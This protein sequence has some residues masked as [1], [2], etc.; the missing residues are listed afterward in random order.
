MPLG[1]IRFEGDEV[2]FRDGT[3]GGVGEDE[4]EWLWTGVI[5]ADLA[6]LQVTGSECCGSRPGGRS[7]DQPFQRSR[8]I[9]GYGPTRCG[10][11]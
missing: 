7:A 2:E 10:D 6:E 5:E 1:A 3:L 8:E 4:L 9:G 11:L